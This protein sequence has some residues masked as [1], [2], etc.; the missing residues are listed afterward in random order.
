MPATPPMALTGLRIADFTQVIAGPYGM[1]LMAYA[2]AEV[3]KVESTRR[4]DSFRQPGY[5]VYGQGINSARPFAEFNRNKRSVSVDMGTGDG[6]T[7]IK[8][9]VAV[10]D[11]VV[12]NFSHGVMN[13]WG[14]DYPSL[15]QIAPGI[16]MLSAQGM[17]QDGPRRDWVTYGP[18]LL[19]YSGFTW[20]WNH[21]DQPEPTGSQVALP[22]YL[23]SVYAA[24]AIIA[25]LDHRRRTGQGQHI[26][27]AQVA[28]AA[29]LLPTTLLEYFVNHHVTPPR[30][31]T[32]PFFAPYG[33]Y[34]CRGEDRWCAITVT[35][36]EEW[37]SLR[38]TLGDPPWTADARFVDMPGR[39]QHRADLDALLAGWTQ[40][41]DAHE[42]MRLLQAEGVPAGAVQNAKDLFNDPHLR[43]RGM[44]TEVEH[45]EMPPLTFPGIPYRM[46]ATP[47]RLLRHAPLLGHDNDYVF[48]E[49]LGL[50]QAEIKRLVEREVI[51]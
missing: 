13:R 18:S 19:A 6:R 23:A 28:T 25:A 31:N 42:V 45:P 9:L 39:V 20:V 15:D 22:D 34:P 26:L 49:L 37:Q 36:E 43:E 12:E 50:T 3:I 11:V 44:L 38:R 21:P 46:S 14:F 17:G 27:L 16:I 24:L 5:G 40:A 2:G 48:R 7:L 8:R 10:S 4:P 32:S 1:Q 29:S 35:S 47:P 33:L 41:H 51:I 30:G